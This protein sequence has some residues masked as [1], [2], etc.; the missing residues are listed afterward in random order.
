MG[1]IVKSIGKV[2]KKVGKSVKSLVKKAGPTL[3]L[4]AGLYAGT[5][6]FGSS[7][8]GATGNLFSWNNFTSGASQI[9]KSVFG[10]LGNMFGGPAMASTGGGGGSIT[11]SVLNAATAG[12]PLLPGLGSGATLNL[13]GGLAGKTGGMSSQT[14]ITGFIKNAMKDSPGLSLMAMSQLIGAGVGFVGDW[15]DDSEE[16]LLAEKKRQFDLEL[17]EAKRQTT[18]AH[19]YAGFAP[20]TTKPHDLPADAPFWQPGP[21]INTGTGQIRM[22]GD[23]GFGRQSTRQFIPPVQKAAQGQAPSMLSQNTNG[24]ISMG[25]NNQKRLS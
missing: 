13:A 17:E 24:M 22:P 19:T 12:D 8:S 5:A 3:L 10:G 11:G 7:L 15:M 21:T 18:L 16:K 14:G 1:S 9:G 6:A 20:G 23:P 2:I 25:T 4:A